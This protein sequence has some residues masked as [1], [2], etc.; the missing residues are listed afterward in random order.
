MPVQPPSV[1]GYE[2]VL[3]KYAF[4]PGGATLEHYLAH[5]Q[6]YQGLKKALAMTP[7]QV[8]EQVKASGLRGRGGAGFPTGLKWQFVDKKSPNPSTS[9]AT[10][11]RAS[12]A[13]SRTIC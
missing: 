12:R 8:I 1:N 2:P 3:T 9:S 7:D 5:Q 4:T 11:T 10:P 6:G 13:P